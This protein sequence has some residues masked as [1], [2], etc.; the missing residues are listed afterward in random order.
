VV[1]LGVATALSACSRPAKKQT[2]S[3]GSSAPASVSAVPDAVDA[4]PAP[5]SATRAAM[6]RASLKPP[7]LTAP[8]DS[9]LGPGGVRYQLLRAGTGDSPDSVDSIVVDF[10]M[11]TA[12]GQL[13]FSSYPDVEPAG[14]SVSTL[15]PNL[16]GL[17]TRLHAGSFVRFWVPRAALAGWRPQEWPDA[18]LVFDLELLK[19]THVVVKDSSGNSIVPVPG[20][21]PD[22]AGPPKDA[23][24]TPSGLRYIYLARAQTRKPATMDDHLDV[25]ATAYVVDGIEVKLVHEG[26]KTGTTLA[27]A[28]GKLAEVLKRLSSGDRVRIWLDKGQGKA[29][30]PEAGDRETILDLNVSF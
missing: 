6:P 25:L 27:R 14:F 9:E 26:I 12:D 2:A 30:I 20:R 28:P 8:A 17:L 22:A 10:S 11:W 15:A 24:S 5:V 13:A 23:E 18:D 3:A 7:P 4:A 21:A 1:L 16:R 29:I 19:V